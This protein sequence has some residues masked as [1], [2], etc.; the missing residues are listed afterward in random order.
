MVRAA[1]CEEVW[2][3]RPP[4][5]DGVRVEETGWEPGRSELL[6]WYLRCAGWSFAAFRATKEKEKENVTVA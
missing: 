4:L 5:A 1:H 6:L 2:F 3:E